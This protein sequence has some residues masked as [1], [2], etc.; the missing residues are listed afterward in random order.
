MDGS[1]M[2]DYI[3]S[4]WPNVP[5]YFGTIDDDSDLQK[6]FSIISSVFEYN[7]SMIEQSFDE[8]FLPSTSALL[9]RWEIFLGL[10]T[11]AGQPIENRRS[12][13]L[14]K[15]RGAGTTT[16]SLI[17]SVAEAYSNG[18]VEVLEYPDQFLFVV[19]FIGARGVPP[20]LEDLKK[21]LQ[22]IKQAHLV[23]DFAFTYTAWKEVKAT[24]WGNLKK[25][26][27]SDVKTRR[28]S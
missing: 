5:D 15:Y 2:L 4:I 9:D 16:P 25:Y 6:K 13:L 21:T 20:N 8:V 22:E 24:T 12:R 17:K 1:A 28:W 7:E 3:R 10:S 19:K 18:E 14:G 23:M 26:K 27:W 11:A